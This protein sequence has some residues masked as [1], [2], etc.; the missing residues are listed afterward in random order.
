MKTHWLWAKTPETKG[1]W[2]FC[3]QSM[4]LVWPWDTRMMWNWWGNRTS[5]RLDGV[6]AGSTCVSLRVLRQGDCGS[7][8]PPFPSPSLPAAVCV[9]KYNSYQIH[10]WSEG[11]CLLVAV[12]GHLVLWNVSE[13]DELCPSVLSLIVTLSSFTFSLSFLAAADFLVPQASYL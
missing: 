11:M 3:P 13:Q 1:D 8:P 6:A 12:W 7:D 5:A 9:I 4:D 2:C 10:S